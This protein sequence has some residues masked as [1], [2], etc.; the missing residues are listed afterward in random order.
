MV[1]SAM[2]RFASIITV[3]YCLAAIGARGNMLDGV[4]AQYSGV[5]E[6][7][8]NLPVVFYFHGTGGRPNVDLVKHYSDGAPCVLVGMN[9]IS[10]G[11]LQA[12]GDMI[13]QEIA[14]FQKVRAAVARKYRH[15]SQRV[16]VTGFSKGG[17]IAAFIA[18]KDASIAGAA[19]LGAGAVAKMPLLDALPKPNSQIYIGIGAE[20]ANYINSVRLVDRLSGLNMNVVLDVWDETGHAMPRARGGAIGLR[21]WFALMVGD[22]SVTEDEANEWARAYLAKL[23]EIDDPRRRLLKLRRFLELPFLKKLGRRGQDIVEAEISHALRDPAAMAEQQAFIAHRKLI[24]VEL[25]KRTAT[26]LHSYLVKYN[27]LLE[28]YAGTITSR[29]IEAEIARLRRVLGLG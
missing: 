19:V 4:V 27:M 11:L 22:E 18:E 16:Y 2:T 6:P 15:D 26:A 3:L 21:Q 29:Y 8:D 28:K 5:D 1:S 12:Q 14:H 13:S 20:D 7:R 9:Y 23:R 24:E 25:R 17:W 10:S